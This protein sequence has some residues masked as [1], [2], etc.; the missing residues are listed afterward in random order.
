M[1]QDTRELLT[2]AERNL[3]RASPPTSSP[4]PTS[5]APAAGRSGQAV[6]AAQ[7]ADRLPDL[8]V[9]NLDPVGQRLPCRFQGHRVPSR[10]IHDHA[11]GLQKAC[12]RGSKRRMWR[13]ISLQI[14]GGRTWI[15]TTDLFL[16]R[17]AL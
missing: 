17:E 14:T 9:V 5:Q 10:V 6:P 16:I 7:L 1:D 2:N 11:F 4:R 12:K 8:H 3:A 13:E 15:R